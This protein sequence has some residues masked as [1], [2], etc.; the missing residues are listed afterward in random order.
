M[1]EMYILL[2]G[3]NDQK[4]EYLPRLASGKWLGAWG[5]TEPNTG[6]DAGNMRT[7]RMCQCLQCCQCV[8]L[9]QCLWLCGVV[10]LCASL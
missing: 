10:C 6:S 1:A 7:T 3:N 5:L 9:R 8:L 4:E 2:F